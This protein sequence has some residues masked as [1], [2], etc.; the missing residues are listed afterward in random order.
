MSV[1]TKSSERLF[2]IDIKY[3]CFGIISNEGIIIAAPPIAAWMISKS[4]ADIKPWLR[5]RNVKVIEV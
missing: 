3:A 1:T 5:G 4:L 2:W